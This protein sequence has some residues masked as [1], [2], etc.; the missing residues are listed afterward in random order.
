MSAMTTSSRF[1]M[2][3][4]ENIGPNYYTTL[5]HWRDNFIANKDKILALG[6]DDKFMRIWEYYLIFSA[7]CFKL[8]ALG[9]YQVV[10][11]RP[12]NRRLG[13]P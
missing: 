11:S 8:R 9:D 3:H 2:E 12:G 1:S 10:F 13:L 5:M 7:A 4:V 6:F